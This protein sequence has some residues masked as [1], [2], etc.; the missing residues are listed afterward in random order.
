MSI[1][2][3]TCWTV[4]RGAAEGNAKERDAF[5]QHYVPVVRA[6]LGARWRGTPLL[7]ELDDA[8]QEVFVDCFKEGG[9]LARV[10]P[11]RPF[12][13]FFYGVVRIV[14]LRHEDRR[15]RRA[16]EEQPPSTFEVETDEPALSEVFDRSWAQSVMEQAA[17]RQAEHAD[18]RGDAA[19]RRLE[20]L[21]LRFQDGLP[22]RE[23]AARWDVDAAHLHREYARARREFREAL[24]EIVGFHQPGS[25]EEVDAECARLL[26]FFA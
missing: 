22:I 11:G 2:E 5:A 4:V 1:S 17:A 24:I 7:Q 16:R 10:D 12:R 13:A 23:I 3:T 19:R 14:A 25:A 8:L 21:A 18:E 15:R 9:A 6:Y 26:D 20:L